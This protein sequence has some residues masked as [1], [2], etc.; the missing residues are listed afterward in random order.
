MHSSQLPPPKALI[1][2]ASLQRHDPGGIHIIIRL[3]VPRGARRAGVEDDQLPR[4]ENARDILDE[5]GRVAHV[6]YAVVI[7]VSGGFV[8][9]YCLGL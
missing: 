2:K 9:E 3:Q 7:R 1:T 5:G 6:I 4:E 8:D